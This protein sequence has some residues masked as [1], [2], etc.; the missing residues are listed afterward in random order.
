MAFKG[1]W[2]KPEQVERQTQHDPKFQALFREYLDRRVR[3]P[4]KADAQLRLAAWCLENGLKEEAMVHYH[5]V[6]RIDPSRDVAWIKLGY[7]KHKDR[8]VKPDELAAQKV[9]I[10]LQ[11][12]ADTHWKS[13]LEKLRDGLESK[14]EARRLKAEQELYQITDPRAVTMVWKTFGTGGDEINFLPP[15]YSRRLKVRRLRSGWPCWRSRG[16]R[17]PCANGQPMRSRGAILET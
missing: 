13:R 14:V 3:T 10:E 6:T 17:R 15:N 11:K 16:D 9:E 5:V 4:Q 2:A 1:K 7:K 8:W 12:H